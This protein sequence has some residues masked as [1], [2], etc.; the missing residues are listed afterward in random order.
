VAAFGAIVVL[1]GLGWLF[2]G[3]DF[4]QYKTFAPK[5]EQVR[6][7]TFEHSRAY[8]AGTIS[9]IRSAQRDYITAPAD[10]RAGLASAI[11][12]Q[13]ADYPDDAMPNDLQ[14]FMVCLRAH[15]NDGYNCAE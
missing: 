4:L 10:R 5:Y 3:N 7:E 12:Q 6:R 1:L 14:H 13:Y 8:N 2:T 9:N 15:Q 11:V